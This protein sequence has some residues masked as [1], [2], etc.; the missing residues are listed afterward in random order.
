MVMTINARAVIIPN[1][2]F[3][4]Y[5]KLFYL[6]RYIY[7]RNNFYNLHH[8]I[9]RKHNDKTN[10]GRGHHGFGALDA[11]FAA[12]DK[13][14]SGKNNQKEKYD[15]CQHKQIADNEVDEKRRVG[16]GIS[17]GRVVIKA[18]AS[19]EIDAFAIGSAAAGVTGY[20][21]KRSRYE[22]QGHLK[23]YT[24]AAPGNLPT[25]R[26]L[27]AQA[28]GILGAYEGKECGF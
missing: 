14:K 21:G 2:F 13:L 12:G 5:S 16:V 20:L 10:N 9:S 1:I 27:A 28:W 6:Y 4:I 11:F 24:T 26:V 7:T 19:A 15:A 8:P 23:Y 17:N 3:I 18:Q 25:P 22:L